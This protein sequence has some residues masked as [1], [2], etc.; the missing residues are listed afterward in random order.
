MVK[1]RPPTLRDEMAALM[2]GLT[3]TRPMGNVAVGKVGKREVARVVVRS[4]AGPE[5]PLYVAVGDWH[6][7][8]ISPA[9]AATTIRRKLAEYIEIFGKALDT[10]GQKA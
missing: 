3:W 2:P 10:P 4:W 7:R 5:W 9:H 6:G 1:T 8:S